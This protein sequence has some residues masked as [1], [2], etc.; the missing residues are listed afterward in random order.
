[1]LFITSRRT[2]VVHASA[3]GGVVIRNPVGEAEWCGQRIDNDTGA[4]RI[5]SACGDGRAN[6]MTDQFARSLSSLR[7]TRRPMPLV[8][9]VITRHLS[10][11]PDR[12]PPEIGLI[13]SPSVMFEAPRGCLDHPH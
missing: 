6:R 12:L 11:D 1:M 3:S 5:A 8:P 2:R 9:P 4:G 13:A 10:P 7:R